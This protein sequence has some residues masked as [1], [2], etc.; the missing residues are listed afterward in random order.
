MNSIHKHTHIHTYVHTYVCTNIRTYVHNTISHA[1]Q[2]RQTPIK[3]SKY[4]KPA[5]QCIGAD[6]KALN[7]TED[8]IVERTLSPFMKAS[9]STRFSI[10]IGA[11]SAWLRSWYLIVPS[12]WHTMRPLL[13]VI[14]E[15]T[16]AD[17]G[18]E[19]KNERGK[20]EK[21]RRK[22]PCRHRLSEVV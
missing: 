15:H 21:A 9:F 16:N 14:C 7:K 11:E 19:E 22:R 12:G 10:S 2:R 13:P 6:S 8:H 1:V 18:R 17:G 4:G 20:K 5:V 3:P